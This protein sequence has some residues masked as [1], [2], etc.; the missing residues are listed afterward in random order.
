M[1]YLIVL[2]VGIVVGFVGG[3]FIMRKNPKYFNIDDMLKAKK[4]EILAELNAKKNMTI[5]EVK[6]LIEKVI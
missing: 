4:V 1:Y 6:K 5:E 3:F 2:V